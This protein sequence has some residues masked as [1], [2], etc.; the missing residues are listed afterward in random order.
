M[1]RWSPRG[2]KRLLDCARYI[3]V[4]SQDRATV[5]RWIDKVYAAVESVETFPRSGGIVREIGRDDIREV[6]HG[7]YR[8]IYRIRRNSVEVISV[9]YGHFLIQSIRSL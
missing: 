8:I 5:L 2:K 1:I 6:L 9:R 4:Q 3:A 7:D